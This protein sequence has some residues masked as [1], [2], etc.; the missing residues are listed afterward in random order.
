MLP[1]NA[2][3]LCD[4]RPD[5]RPLFSVSQMDLR[6]TLDRLAATPVGLPVRRTERLVLRPWREDDR[7]PFAELNADPEVMRHFPACL[8]RAE[9]DALLDR[10]RLQAARRGFGIWAVEAR[11]TKEFVG[12][13]GLSVPTWEASFT[14]AVEIG[15]RLGRAWWGRGLA[16]EAT[17]D[18]LAYA[19]EVLRLPQIVS[20]T[21]PVNERSWKLMERVGMSPAGRFAHPTLPEGHPLREHVLYTLDAPGSRVEHPP[22]DLPT[23]VPA[24]APTPGVPR[25]WIDGDGCPRVVKEVVWKAAQR[26]A[27]DVTMVANRSIVV[28]RHRRIR[29]VLVEKGLDVADDWLVAHAGPGELVITADVPLAAELVPRGVD[30]LSPRGEWFTPSN[31]GEKLSLRDYFTE[32]RESGLIEG[33]GPAQFDERAKRAFANGLDRWITSKR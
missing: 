11:A 25:V 30:V 23:E 29:T 9:S 33:S 16:T 6:A 18:A 26:D 14:P 1:Q 2:M 27:I 22:A 12:M 20:F 17:R 3:L 10:M 7:G 13:V 8:S 5:G 15:W 24:P 31:I 4:C 19:F 32:A 28:P 21:A